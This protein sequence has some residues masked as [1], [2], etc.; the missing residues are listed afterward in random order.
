MGLYWVTHRHF[1]LLYYPKENSVYL[2]L[3]QLGEAIPIDFR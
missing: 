1:I 3:D 2:L